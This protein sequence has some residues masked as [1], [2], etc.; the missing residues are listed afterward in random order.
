[1]QTKR[2]LV[3]GIPIKD[4]TLSEINTICEDTGFALDTKQKL[5]TAVEIEYNE[6]IYI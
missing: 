2:Q 5:I 1:M 4:M 6:N 3:I